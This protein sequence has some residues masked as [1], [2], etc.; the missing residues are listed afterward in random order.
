MKK[1]EL[2]TQ[3]AGCTGLRRRD[4]ELVLNTAL[5]KI[6]AALERGERVQ[7]TGFGTFELRQTAERAGHDPRTQEPIV[8]PASRVAAFR[9][10]QGLR[11]RIDR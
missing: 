11:K 4:V 1:S 7:L 5:E 9:P 3:T 6:C 8:I 2:I 10:C